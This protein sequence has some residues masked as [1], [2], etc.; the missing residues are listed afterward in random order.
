MTVATG[1][2]ASK[3]VLGG[4]DL[5]STS[6]AALRAKDSPGITFQ[7]WTLRWAG[8]CWSVGQLRAG[9]DRVRWSNPRWY[10][11][12]DHALRGLLERC[13]EGDVSE[14]FEAVERVERCYLEMGMA[15]WAAVQ[16]HQAAE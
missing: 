15:L 11:R 3:P 8:D 13:V 7:G 14:L 6:E 4:D 5:M 2:R 12:L 9:K 1:R 10:G 16:A